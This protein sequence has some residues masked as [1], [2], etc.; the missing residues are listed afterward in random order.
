MGLDFAGEIADIGSDNTDIKIGDRVAGMNRRTIA[1]YCLVE[2]SS[3]TKVPQ[4]FTFN[5]AAGLGCAYST[6]M[7]V[8]EKMD[9]K[10][11]F[12]GKKILVIGA[13]GGCGIAGVQMAKGMKASEIVGVCSGKNAEFV[14]LM[15]ADAI[16]D[17][18]KEKVEDKYGK[19]HFDFIYD[20]ASY[21]GGNEDYFPLF[22][23]VLK[24]GGTAIAING[25]PWAW[26][27]AFLGV[28][29]KRIQL[30]KDVNHLDSGRCIAKVFE[31]FQATN[32]KPVVHKEYKFTTEDCF[33]AY[34]ETKSRRSRGKNIINIASK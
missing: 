18:T 9:K 34:Q 2:I 15:G 7:Q 10:W 23:K 3:L 22:D 6:T 29:G 21:S 11:D 33:A 31:N 12:T 25:S 27:K 20:T 24:K 5:E 32:M 4:E 28:Q 1:E 26:T 13:S 17:Y 16:V 14:K 30:F 8:Y 19:D